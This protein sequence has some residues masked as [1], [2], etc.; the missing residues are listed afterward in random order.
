ML[1]ASFML[2]TAVLATTEP[3]PASNLEWALAHRR[4]FIVGGGNDPTLGLK[5]VHQHGRKCPLGSAPARL[6]CASSG[7]TLRLWELARHSQG[8]AQPLG[9]Q[10]LPRLLERAASKA[11]DYTAF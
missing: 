7:R 5:F 3:T 1:V 6:L 8:E 9:A 4:A 11:A 2:A 10:P